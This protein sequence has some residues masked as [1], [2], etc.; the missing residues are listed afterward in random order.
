MELVTN[1]SWQF[2]FQ[3]EN[4]KPKPRTASGKKLPAGAVAIFGGK[5]RSNSL[6]KTL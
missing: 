4:V 1:S 3:L 2:F 6:Y 5:N